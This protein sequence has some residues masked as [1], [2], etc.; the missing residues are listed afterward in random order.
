[1]ILY[2][3]PHLD[4]VPLSC[5]AKILSMHNGPKDVVVATIFSKSDEQNKDYY[6][7]RKSEERMALKLLGVEHF[8][9]DFLDAPYRLSCY[10]SYDRILWGTL[11]EEDLISAIATKLINLTS[12]HAVSEICI[13][14][15]VGWHI[16]HLIVHKV[17]Q[18]LCQSLRTRLSFYEDRPYSFVHGATQIRLLELGICNDFSIDL[19]DFKKSLFEMPWTKEA[20]SKPEDRQYLESRINDWWSLTACDTNQVNLKASR[21]QFSIKSPHLVWD[22][23]LSYASQLSSLYPTKKDFMNM[24]DQYSLLLGSANNYTECDWLV[25]VSDHFENLL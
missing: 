11:D 18:R 13:P 2:L 25:E 7:K 24:S 19:N 9:C 4:D 1:M 8:F 12:S 20:L 10:S 3:S 17:G 16:D 22:I 23:L 5:S 15:G 14:L 21:R 6:E